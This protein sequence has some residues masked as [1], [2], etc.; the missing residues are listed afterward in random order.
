MIPQNLNLNVRFLIQLFFWI[1][2]IFAIMHETARTERKFNPKEPR[3]GGGI[4]PPP[5]HFL[6]YLS[7]LL[8]FR[9]E[10]SWLLSFKPCAQFKTIFKTRLGVPS[11]AG[12]LLKVIETCVSRGGS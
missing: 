11:I 2:E 7:R 10:T 4:R 8:F 9:A 5:W 3:G 1:F 6:L 12:R